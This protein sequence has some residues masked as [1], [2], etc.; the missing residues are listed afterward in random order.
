MR[1]RQLELRLQTTDGPYG[2]SIDFPNGLVVVRADNSMGKSTCV[3]AILV[4]LGMEQMLTTSQSELPLTPSVLARLEGANNRPADVL[5]SEVYLEIEN[6]QGSRITVQRTLKGTRDNHLITVYQGPALTQPAG[7]FTATDFFVNRPGG[8]SRERG[9][10]RYLAGF[11]G[12]DLPKVPSFDGNETP[13][14]LQC[15]F[16]F[17]VVEQTRGWSSILPPVPTHLRVKDAHKR[18]VEFILLIRR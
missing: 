12:W 17:F 18:A 14:Y 7:T 16:P 10:H 2:T 8:A 4:A 13:L 5:E 11:L 6:G 3:K 9:F 1:L 15:L